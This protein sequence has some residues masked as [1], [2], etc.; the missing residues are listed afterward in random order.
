MCW[1]CDHVDLTRSEYLEHIRDVIACCG[2]AIQGVE[3]GVEGDRRRSPSV[4]TVGLTTLGKPEVV[5]TG[6][7][8]ARAARLANVVAAHMAHGDDVPEPGDRV[9][10][11]DGPEIEIVEVAEPGE[12]L[13]VAVE[14]FGPEVRALQLVHADDRGHW[15][16]ERGFRGSR[17]G[18]PLLG[19]RVS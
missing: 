15:P 4:Y 10:L 5:V 2:Y 12:H 7:A 3:G 9:P 17:G 1:L 19:T 8:E 18:Q 6:M 11:L 16:W 13:P 14:L